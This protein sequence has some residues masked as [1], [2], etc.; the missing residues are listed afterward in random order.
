MIGIWNT[1]WTV[2][3]VKG[4]TSGKFTDGDCG[5]GYQFT[6]RFKVP[7]CHNYGITVSDGDEIAM[8]LDMEKL[9]LSY[10]VDGKD[11]GIAFGDIEQTQ[12]YAAI[13][14]YHT[15]GSVELISYKQL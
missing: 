10:A 4:V 3:E 6:S 5:Y 14:T 7:Y 9:T 2:E 12:Y 11:Q 13:Y 8:C 15:N 1:E